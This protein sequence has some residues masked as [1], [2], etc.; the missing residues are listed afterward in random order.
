MNWPVMYQ[1]NIEGRLSRE[2][3]EWFDGAEI[4]WDANGS[5]SL[6]GLVQDEAAP[7]GILNRFCDLI[8]AITSVQKLFKCNDE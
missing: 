6:V 7:Y 4:H 5:T 2:W 8:L 3:V 1:F